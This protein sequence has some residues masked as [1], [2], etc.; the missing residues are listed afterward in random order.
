MRGATEPPRTGQQTVVTLPHDTHRDDDGA[1][2]GA[3]ERHQRDAAVERAV[4]GDAFDAVAQHDVERHQEERREQQRL[5]HGG[6]VAAPPPQDAGGEQG[7]LGS[8]SWPPRHHGVQPGED[9]DRR[10]HPGQG[11]TDD[12]P[13]HRRSRRRGVAGEGAQRVEILRERLVADERL[14]PVREPFGGL[15]ADRGQAQGVTWGTSSSGAVASGFLV[16]API[17]SPI[18][19]RP[20][21]ITSAS[22]TN[23]AVCQALPWN[24]KP[25]MWPQISETTSAMTQRYMLAVMR[26]GQRGQPGHRHGAETPVDAGRASMADRKAADTAAKKMACSTISGVRYCA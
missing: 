24:R 26:G 13:G 7:G 14:N 12:R 17:R 15:Q 4:P 8:G 10:G 18:S 2:G 20:A 9:H 3:D 5:R 25:M 6:G 11:R 1:G 19:A 23:P 22:R 16:A 21:P